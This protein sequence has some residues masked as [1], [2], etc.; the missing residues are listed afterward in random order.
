MSSTR[1]TSAMAFAALGERAALLD[2]LDFP[3]LA[4]QHAIERGLRQHLS[5]R[6]ESDLA[7]IGPVDGLAANR[8]RD[9]FLVEALG[10]LDRGS[11]YADRLGGHTGFIARHPPVGLLVGL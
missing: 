1:N 8:I 11:P 7:E 4:V 9:H 10:L 2:Q 6:G 3:V 5:V